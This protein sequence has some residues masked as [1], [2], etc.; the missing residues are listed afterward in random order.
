MG[1][2]PRRDTRLSLCHNGKFVEYQFRSL[3]QQEGWQRCI[4]HCW[5]N[6]HSHQKHALSATR[7]VESCSIRVLYAKNI[8]LP[9]TK[10]WGLCVPGFTVASR[11]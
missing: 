5:M 8:V 7:G 2:F 6:I 11:K 9:L 1:G 4:R 3:Q 10:F